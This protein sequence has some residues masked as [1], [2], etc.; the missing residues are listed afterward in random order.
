MRTILYAWLALVTACTGQLLWA[1]ELVAPAGSSAPELNV[2]ADGNVYLS[3]LEPQDSGHAL[4]FA[5]FSDNG[6]AEPRTAASGEHWFVSWADWPS[7]TALGDG[8]L[9][10]H[11]LQYIGASTLAHEIKLA[12]SRNGGASWEAP[13][14][15]HDD[16]TETEHGFVSTLPSG[17]RLD[18]VWLDGR[19]LAEVRGT[20]VE[21]A[22][23]MTLRHAV[24]DPAGT[25]STATVTEVDART[26]DCCQT[27]IAAVLGGL[28]VAYRDRT[29]DDIR[30]IVV[31]RYVGSEWSAPIAVHDDHWRIEGCPVNGPALDARGAAVAVAWFTAQSNQARVFAALSRDSG[32]SF[33]PPIR[34]DDGSTL[35]HVDIA[36]LDNDD[37]A[38]AWVER[39]RHSTQIKL[40]RA[41]A[42][43]TIGETRTLNVSSAAAATFPRLVRHGQNIVAAWT[44]EADKL[45]RVHALTIPIDYL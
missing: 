1:A 23:A 40:R 8:T 16:G 31:R 17:S 36:M 37:V 13:I 19:R 29:E 22:Q 15:L 39:Q 30:D 32:R 42:H 2:G 26:C 27:S 28:V 14:T 10:A 11:W 35:G 44:E 5:V 20:A 38:V 4:R 18:V 25:M 34:I 24:L 21:E 41:R 6:W 33:G 12:V 43:G 7:V 9:V 3:W 45:G